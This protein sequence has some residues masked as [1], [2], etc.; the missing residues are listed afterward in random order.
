MC[1]T[2]LPTLF[3]L[4]VDF[5]TLPVVQ[6]MFT[7][8]DLLAIYQSRVAGEV[9]V[10]FVLCAFTD[11]WAWYLFLCGVRLISWGEYYHF[12]R[13]DAQVSL[14]F[15]L[16]QIKLK[17]NKGSSY[18]NLFWIKIHSSLLP[19]VLKMINFFLLKYSGFE[20]LIFYLFGSISF[21][22]YLFCL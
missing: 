1:W 19:W 5:Q 3:A 12:L 11:L 16:V 4:Q 17:K 8:L 14:Q 6:H 21:N 18:C 13:E 10:L 20:Q 15:S 2:L 22:Y 9:S 7:M